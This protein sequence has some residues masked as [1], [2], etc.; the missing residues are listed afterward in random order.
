MLHGAS[1]FVVH[2]EIMQPRIWLIF[3]LGVT[4]VQLR[5]KTSETKELISIAR[6]LKAICEKHNV[7]FLVNDRV[8]VAQAVDA[9]GVHIGQDDMSTSSGSFLLPLQS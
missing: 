2:A 1:R 5:D 6:G 7:P 3:R 8:D 4:I 9:D